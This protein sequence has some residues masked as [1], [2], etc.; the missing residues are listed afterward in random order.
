MA[1]LSCDSIQYKGVRQEEHSSAEAGLRFV[2]RCQRIEWLATDLVTWVST[3]F[4]TMM[5]YEPIQ[6]SVKDMSD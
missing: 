2:D 1:K 3:K 5:D 4:D 6:V